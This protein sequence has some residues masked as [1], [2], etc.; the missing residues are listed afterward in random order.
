AFGGRAFEYGSAWGLDGTGAV[1]IWLPPN[2]SADEEELV[3]ILGDSISPNQQADTFAVL[4]QMAAA[5]P[6]FPHWYLPWLA[7]EPGRQGEGLGS[8]LL[9]HGLEIVDAEH[10]PAFLETPNPRT[11][12]LYERHGFEVIATAQAGSCPPVTSMLR[13]AVG[14]STP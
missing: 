14:G 10:L 1:A 9:A 7:V 5:H 11:V 12:P 2:V 13:A 8:T 6:S 4:E 3:A